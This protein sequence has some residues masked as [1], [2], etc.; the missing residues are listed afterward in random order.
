[1]RAKREGG[2]GRASHLSK[3]TDKR[4]FGDSCAIRWGQE[5]RTVQAS[6]ARAEAEWMRRLLQGKKN[7]RVG[8]PVQD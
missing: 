7:L 2:A 1:M 5:E 3:F 4:G 6:T 8:K